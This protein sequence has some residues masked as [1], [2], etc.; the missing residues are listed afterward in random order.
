MTIHREQRASEADRLTQYRGKAVPVPGGQV[1]RVA[2]ET[3]T[4]KSKE[5]PGQEQ[6]SASRRKR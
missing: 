4:V 2:R 5:S 3:G 1:G 6:E